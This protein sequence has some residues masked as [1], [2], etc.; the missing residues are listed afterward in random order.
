MADACGLFRW[1][2]IAGRYRPYRCSRRYSALR[3]RPSA[4]AAWLTL[5][6]KRASAF[7]MSSASTSSRLISSRRGGPSRP[8][9][10]AQVDGADDVALRHQD[11][12]LHGMI[13][14]ADVARPGV[15]QQRLD[16]AL[17]EAGE[18]LAVVLG[19]LPQE[20]RGQQRDVFAAVAQR[21]QAD[22]DG[23]Q[24]EQQVLAETG[25]RRRRRCRSALV[26]E[27]T[28]TS[29]RRVLD[30]PTRSNSPVSRVRSSLACSPCE[31]LA[32][33]SRKSVPPSAISKR[34]T[35]SLLASVNA[36]LTWPNSSLSK[37]PSARPPVFTVTSGRVERSETECSVCATSPL[38]VPF[39]PVMRTLASDGPT[40]EITSS[41]GRMAADCGDQL[42][43]ALGA[44][45]AV[46]GF[47]ALAL[48][49]GAAEFDL[50]LQDGGEARVVPGLL[51]EVARA[52]AH[53]F[54]G[55]L[56]RCPTRS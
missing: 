27:K 41:T 18:R 49:Q 17:V 44:Q 35:R 52:A 8:R 11:G 47:Q 48:A 50:G 22:L 3:L 28:R 21:R 2:F 40:R 20:V 53:G 36:P 46:L 54:D 16:G 33:S 23:V 42:R 19:M 13:Q 4:L 32:I 25:L 56:D 39:S 37:T 1:T 26:A 15:R 30:E 6:L 31:M 7:L 12:A 10:Q 9:A 38:P 5:P 14:L 55:E 29:T 24:A 34:P 51:D 45:R 43:K